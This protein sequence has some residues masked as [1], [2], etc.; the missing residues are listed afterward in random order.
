MKKVLSIIILFFLAI[1]I[2]SFAQNVYIFSYFKSRSIDGLHLAYSHDGY[3]WQALNNDSSFLKPTAGK[4]K[5]M[6]DPCI[7]KDD[8]GV[9][10]MVWTV[11]WTERIIGYAS[12]PDLVHWSKQKEIPVMMHEPLAKNAWAPEIFYDDRKK[13]F[14]I[15]WATAIKGK[16]PATDTLGDNDHRI[17]YV[18]T[19]DFNTF[20]RAKLLYEHGFNVIDATIQK[21]GRKRYVM[22]LKDE[23]IKPVKK[24]LHIATG[25]YVTKGWSKPSP[26]ITGNY[27]AEGPTAIKIGDEW[28]VYFDKYRDHKYGA[29]ASKDLQMWTD[30]S[31][32]ISLPPGIRHGTIFKISKQEFENLQA[33]LK[34]Q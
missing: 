17:Y 33:G 26:P 18:T 4:D 6:R 31:D 3:K 15:Y 8:K 27:W 1:P 13:N 20:S 21:V 23:T 22:F 19:K 2:L 30:V 32:K 10:H 29:I 34:S 28:I 25:K 24:T 12:S 5:L 7:L 14:V 11:S 9:F 16:F